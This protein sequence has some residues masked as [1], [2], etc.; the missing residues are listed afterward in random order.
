[1]VNSLDL[2]HHDSVTVN[3]LYDIAMIWQYTTSQ[4]VMVM[5][6]MC[7]TQSYLNLIAPSGSSTLKVESYY[8]WIKPRLRDI[9]PPVHVR[10]IDAQYLLTVGLVAGLFKL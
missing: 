9:V 10:L 8:I 4:N 7:T 3:N 1:M 6:L 5:G 2:L